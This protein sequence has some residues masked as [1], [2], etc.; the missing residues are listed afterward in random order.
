MYIKKKDT[1]LQHNGMIAKADAFIERQDA[2]IKNRA[3]LMRTKK[4]SNLSAT[5]RHCYGG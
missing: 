5:S 4:K 2:N 1:R 3:K